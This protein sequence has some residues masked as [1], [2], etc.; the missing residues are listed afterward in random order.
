MKKVTITMEVDADKLAGLQQ[1]LLNPIDFSDLEDG[2]NIYDD[3]IYFKNSNEV[4]ISLLR[5]LEL[6][7]SG[8]YKENIIKQIA[9]YYDK[10][11]TQNV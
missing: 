10:K 8:R 9:N 5:L 4:P 7:T 3:S 11:G 6:N 1:F 2:F